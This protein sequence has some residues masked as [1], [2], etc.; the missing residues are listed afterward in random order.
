MTTAHGSMEHRR[1]AVVSIE[2]DGFVGSGEASTLPGFSLESQQAAEA[3]L[4]R[5]AEFGTTPATPAAATAVACAHANL[6]AA[7]EGLSLAAWLAGGITSPS[8]RCQSVVGDGEVEVCASAAKTAVQSGHIAVKV[9]VAAGAPARDI[10]RVLAVR[11]AVGPT[12]AVRL[13]A[14]GGW[15]LD[16]AISVLGHLDQADVEFVEEPTASPDEFR[17]IAGATGITIALDEHAQSVDVIREV[18]GEGVDVVVA[19]P[20]VLGGPLAA[21]TAAIDLLDRGLRVVISSFMDGPVGLDAAVQVAA[22]LP[23]DEIHG[24]GTASMFEVPFPA[25]LL[26]VD[27]NLILPV[28]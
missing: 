23:T 20:A 26:P 8:V 14:N 21:H 6:E 5:W 17:E 1:L 27:G 3:Q 22:A 19:K 4:A 11:E 10:D 18:A 2:D 7:K 9:K 25:H 15:D 12:T 16:V 24:L 28:L 13:D